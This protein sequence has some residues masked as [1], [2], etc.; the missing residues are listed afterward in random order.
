MAFFS[1]TVS[2]GAM[3]GI[4]IGFWLGMT[5]PTIPMLAVSLAMAAA[6]MWL[7]ENTELLTDTLMSLLL[8]GAVAFG[9]IVMSQL[10]T[11]PGDLQQF[12]FGDILAVGETEIWEAAALAVVVGVGLF[13]I[14]RA[15]V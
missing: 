14:G 7:K 4:A 11:R 15:H 2:H 13:Q 9:V 12:L 10:K 8:S 5:D 1:D 3:A 6:L